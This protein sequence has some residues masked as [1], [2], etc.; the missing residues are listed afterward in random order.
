[1][2][3]ALHF[4]FLGL[5]VVPLFGFL[6]TA[7]AQEPPPSQWTFSEVDGLSVGMWFQTRE[8]I[9]STK[10]DREGPALTVRKEVRELTCSEWQAYVEAVKKFQNSSSWAKYAEAQ[11]A[12]GDRSQL[13]WDLSHS[14]ARQNLYTFLPWHRLWLRNLEKELQKIDPEV[15][16]PYWNWALDSEDPLASPVLSDAY[17]GGN[18]DPNTDGCIVDGPFGVKER[19]EGGKRNSSCVRRA[20][21]QDPGGLLNLAHVKDILVGLDTFEAF[22]LCLENCPGMYGYMN[23]FLGGRGAKNPGDPLFLSVLAYVDMLWWTWQR[24]HNSMKVPGFMGDRN[25]ILLPFQEHVQDVFSTEEMGYTYWMGE[26]NK[27]VGTPSCYEER[28][29]GGD[30]AM[31]DV[32][33]LGREVFERLPSNVSQLAKIPRKSPLP[34]VDLWRQW[35]QVKLNHHHLPTPY[36]LE[37]DLEMWAR[38]SAWPSLNASAWHSEEDFGLGIP[39]STVL[40][41]F[42]SRTEDEEDE[43]DVCGSL[44]MSLPEVEEA[45]VVRRP[46][47]EWYLNVFH[48]LVEEELAKRGSS[49]GRNATAMTYQEAM[50]E[51]ER[52][53]TSVLFDAIDPIV[54]F[55]ESRVLEDVWVVMEKI[56]KVMERESWNASSPPQM[57]GKAYHLDGRDV[58]NHQGVRLYAGAAQTNVTEDSVENGQKEEVEATSSDEALQEVHRIIEI[59]YTLQMEQTSD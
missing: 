52:L 34:K 14:D 40:P 13:I 19:E 26:E 2:R 6:A 24:M 3:S 36:E 25:E 18:G 44:L 33:G 47:P 8:M 55:E 35:I 42:R 58:Y 48:L 12:S 11:D 7:R 5:L 27:G 1:M 37:K 10:S 43:G 57:G 51:A 46:R 21:P 15:A 16:I 9:H 41:D 29:A 4:L 30:A 17:F 39:V 38:Y 50:K 49:L 45:C 20:L 23:I 31:M 53:L 56:L 54:R 22:N 32:V 59:T 28:G